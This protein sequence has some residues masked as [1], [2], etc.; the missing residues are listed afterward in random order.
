LARATKIPVSE[1]TDGQDV[2][3]DHIYVIPANANMIIQDGVLRLVPRESPRGRHMP[4]DYFLR[5]LAEDREGQAIAVILSGTASDGTLGCAAVK[6]AG[7]ITFAQE[8]K[9]AKYSGM[10][11]SAIAPLTLCCRPKT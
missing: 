2:Q 4:I 6:T 10:P 7:G 1:V 5:S 9:S 3:R 8:E 11:R